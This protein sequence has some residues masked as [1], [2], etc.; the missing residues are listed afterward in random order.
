MNDVKL[1]MYIKEVSELIKDRNYD[2]KLLDMMETKID[3]I[4]TGVILKGNVNTTLLQRVIDLQNQ[5][6]ELKRTRHVKKR[7]S[8]TQMSER[9][10]TLRRR[11]RRHVKRLNKLKEDE[12]G[13]LQ[14]IDAQELEIAWLN[15]NGVDF[16]P[17]ESDDDTSDEM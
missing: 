14:Q 17:N 3:T 2:S 7:E 8:K 1:S 6:K 5:K 12:K 4:G 11:L 15:N 13:I 10:D 16:F 9:H